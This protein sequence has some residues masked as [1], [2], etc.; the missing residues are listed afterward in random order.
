MDKVKIENILK[1]LKRGK[2][3]LGGEEILA[4]HQCF[5]YLVSILNEIKIKEEQAKILSNA[6]IVES[7]IKTDKPKK[8]KK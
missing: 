5:A 1:L 8:G 4:F 3:E 2:W 7:P 6:T